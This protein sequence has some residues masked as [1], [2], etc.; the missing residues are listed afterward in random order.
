MDD[1]GTG[2][3]YFD[4]A[5]ARALL[6]DLRS[7]TDGRMG[8][9]LSESIRSVVRAGSRRTSDE[10]E[11]AIAAIALLLAEHSPELLDGAPDEEGLRR[12]LAQADTELTPGR[13]L[14]ATG[15]LTRIS[16]G[17]DNEWYDAQGAGGSL[18]AALESVR[19]LRH[20]LVD[21]AR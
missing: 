7:I 4:P 5:G 19:H 6:A 17:G 3:P 10:V 16:L 9:R 13:R 12:W 14:A 11:R 1:V 18:A 21:Q 2:N 15:A 20:K 8:D